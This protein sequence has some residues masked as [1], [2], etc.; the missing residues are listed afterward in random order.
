[1]N[2]LLELMRVTLMLTVL[3]LT[4]VSLAPVKRV[5]TVMESTAMVS[6]SLG[7]GLY[8]IHIMQCSHNAA[9]N[10]FCKMA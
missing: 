3:T 2:V 5:T 8:N 6:Y 10:Y 1:M 9:R 7:D 4:E